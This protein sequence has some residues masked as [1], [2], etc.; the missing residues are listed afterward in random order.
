MYYDN[1]WTQVD[2]YDFASLKHLCN[3]AKN[4]LF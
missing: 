3:V 2:K 1:R 4:I